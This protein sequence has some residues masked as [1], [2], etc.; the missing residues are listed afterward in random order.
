MSDASTLLAAL[1]DVPEL[2]WARGALLSGSGSVEW[3]DGRSAL[4]YENLEAC[5]VGRPPRARLLAY[6]ERLPQGTEVVMGLEDARALGPLP[7][8]REEVAVVH[9]QQGPPPAPP[10]I[11]GEVRILEADAPLDLRHLPVDF[12]SELTRARVSS[13]LAVAFTEGLAVAFSYSGSETETWW[14]VSIDTHEP[15]RRQGYAAATAHALIEHMRTRSKRAVWA[16][17]ESNIASL[18]LAARLGFTPVA[19]VASIS[20]AEDSR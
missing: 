14:D 8:W 3:T 12:V 20:R 10:V 17:L 2:V 1:P 15:F 9:V 5:V 16:A 7:G 19:R 6:L 13:P 11:R 4:L 18:E